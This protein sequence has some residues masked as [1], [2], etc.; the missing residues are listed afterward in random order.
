MMKVDRV[1]HRALVFW[2]SV[3]ILV[4]IVLP[5]RG[6]AIVAGSTYS[7]D[8]ETRTYQVKIYL[9][10]KKPHADSWRG[11][12]NNRIQEAPYMMEY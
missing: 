1:L 4:A 3:V 9:D 11:N 8:R 7:D 12:E 2:L 10:C 5:V 6:S